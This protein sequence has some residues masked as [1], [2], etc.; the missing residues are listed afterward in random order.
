M[1]GKRWRSNGEARAPSESQI[2]AATFSR[3]V[4]NNNNSYYETSSQHSDQ[5]VQARKRRDMASRGKRSYIMNFFDIDLGPARAVLPPAFVS[6]PFR[7]LSIQHHG[8]KESEKILK[9]HSKLLE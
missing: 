8:S 6:H 3:H 7:M 2:C 4:D 9:F 5:E 1:P